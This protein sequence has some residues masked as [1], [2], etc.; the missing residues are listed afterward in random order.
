[1]HI[2]VRVP[3]DYSSYLIGCALE[4]SDVRGWLAELSSTD[5]DQLGIHVLGNMTEVGP[6]LGAVMEL[7]A[8]SPIAHRL[9]EL[10]TFDFDPFDH[11][12]FGY[13]LLDSLRLDPRR[14]PALER[15][16]LRGR[17]LGA[18]GLDLWWLRELNLETCCL[19]DS[20]VARLAL[21]DWS[22]LERLTL[23]TGTAANR[24]PGL[25][26]CEPAP[27][28]AVISLLHRQPFP[29]LRHIGIM[30]CAWVD[31]LC[32]LLPRSPLIAQL[33]SLDL[34]LGAMTD[35]GAHALASAANRLKHL[36]LNLDANCLT[37]DGCQ[38]LA[39]AGLR[40]T[41]RGQKPAHTPPHVSFAV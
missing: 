13:H 21:T 9:H 10:V 29:S 26:L 36:R 17:G 1:M 4:L 33:E 25:P 27:L 30:N 11:E 32:R 12:Q 2:D 24:R 35:E 31:E 5:V 23:W 3:D 19:E 16:T 14:F 15:L 34:S 38:R 39:R 40:T 7:V 8:H 28:D 22:L 6:T 18:E 41:H 37:P 20:T